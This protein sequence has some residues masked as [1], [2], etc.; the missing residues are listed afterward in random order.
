MFR[1]YNVSC[2]IF[3]LYQ[4]KFADQNSGIKYK[5]F[6]LITLTKINKQFRIFLVKTALIPP[7][8]IDNSG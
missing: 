4:Q 3:F 2:A 5:H 1:T 7:L 8:D 6:V